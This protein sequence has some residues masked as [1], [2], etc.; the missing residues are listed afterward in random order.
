LVKNPA[1]ATEVLRTLTHVSGP[2]NLMLAAN[3]RF[4]DGLDVSWYWDTPFELIADQAQSIIC[5]GTR[6]ADMALRLKYAGFTGELQV[7]EPPE[8]AFDAARERPGNAYF[9]STY[10]AT[11]ELQKILAQRNLKKAFFQE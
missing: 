10:T 11:L 1:G 7:V 9:L 3:D 5:T 2:L 8:K 6:A 4:A